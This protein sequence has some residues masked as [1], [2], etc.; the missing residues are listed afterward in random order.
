[1]CLCGIRTFLFSINWV[2]I[3]SSGASIFTAFVA[4]RALTIWKQKLTVERK[5]QFLD[6]ITDASHEY[7]QSITSALELIKFL[8]I[9]IE[10]EIESVFPTDKRKNA[11]IINYIEKKGKI[12]QTQLLK[13][14]EVAGPAYNKLASLNVKGNVLALSNYTTCYDSCRLLLNVYER[15]QAVALIIGSDT[16]VWENEMVQNS[17]ERLKSISYE[18]I[19]QQCNSNHLQFLEF[20]KNE[21]RVLLK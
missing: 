14:L 16:M 21:Y 1:M 13:Y 9:G 17:L 19:Q 10:A 4:Y 7:I 5:L 20:V 11:G 3:V 18:E 15:I 8:K 12:Q 6:S 2:N